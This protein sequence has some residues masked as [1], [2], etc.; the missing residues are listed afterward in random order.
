LL[1]QTY[2]VFL[3]LFQ[4]ITLCFISVACLYNFIPNS[5]QDSK[6]AFSSFF[7][8]VTQTYVDM[9]HF[10]FQLCSALHQFLSHHYNPSLTTYIRK[11]SFLMTSMI[12]F[13]FQFPFLQLFMSFL[14][15][16]FPP[17]S[18]PFAVSIWRTV[19]LIS[20]K[21]LNAFSVSRT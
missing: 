14:W 7:I 20:Y 13:F 18:F 19:L 11:T 16:T 3:H 10:E 12:W 6:C 8:N 9:N 2:F 15:T 4:I 1:P 17:E 5:L 21:I